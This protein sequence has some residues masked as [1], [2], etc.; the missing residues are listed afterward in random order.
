VTGPPPAVVNLWPTAH[1]THPESEESGK[2]EGQGDEGKNDEGEEVIAAPSGP[3]MAPPRVVPPVVAPTVPTTLTVRAS[4]PLPGAEART[5]IPTPTVAPTPMATAQPTV[6][7]TQPATG[8]VS[9]TTT[10]GAQLP[11]DRPP[12]TDERQILKRVA[13]EAAAS[14]RGSQLAAGGGPPPPSGPAAGTVASE[15]QV[16]PRWEEAKAEV[17]RW[18]NLSQELQTAA[19]AESTYTAFRESAKMAQDALQA[20]EEASRQTR[21]ERI[22]AVGALP[23]TGLQIP[24]APTVLEPSQQ[25]ESDCWEGVQALAEE[26]LKRGSDACRAVPPWPCLGS[27]LAVHDI[28]C[29]TA[30]PFIKDCLT[31]A[32]LIPHMNYAAN[33]SL[34]TKRIIT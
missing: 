18:W 21:E 29:T 10:T 31:E 7:L 2:E 13:T 3:V 32:I 9:T 28:R 34:D 11:R 23:L 17:Q 14:Q 1:L 12:A 5:V 33:V 16:D 15:A 22:A 4:A 24:G 30:T 6:P 25:F 19:R 8:P 20:T 26:I 27:I